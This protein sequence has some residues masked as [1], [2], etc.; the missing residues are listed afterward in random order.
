VP[1][2]IIN[3]RHCRYPFLVTPDKKSLLNMST[4]RTSKK[5]ARPEDDNCIEFI[6]REDIID[7]ENLI[8]DDTND[9]ILNEH[10]KMHLSNF[11]INK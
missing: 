4:K 10:A 6:D 5:C 8:S 2:K 9:E 11:L 1:G 7:I 3:D